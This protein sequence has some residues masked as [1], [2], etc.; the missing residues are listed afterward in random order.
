MPFPQGEVEMLEKVCFVSVSGGK[1][2]ALTLALAVERYGGSEIP[3]VGVFSDT[4]WEHPLTYG[5]LREL[6]E[7]FGIRI[8]RIS[9]FEGGLPALIRRKRIFPSARR[10]FCT[11]ILKTRALA[12]FYRWFYFQFPFKGAEVWSGIRREESKSRRN[13]SDFVLKKGDSFH[14]VSFPFDVHYVYPIKDLREKEVFSELQKRGVPVNP[15]YSLG[16][17]RVGC[18]PCFLSKREIVHLIKK[19]LDGDRFALSRLEELKELDSSCSSRIHINHSL[20]E[21]I[22]IA[23][24]ERKKE[25]LLLS[26]PFPDFQK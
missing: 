12:K 17:K 13:I 2:S 8:Q 9:G 26:L 25:S 6:E 16:Y 22:S 15:L 10:R 11:E 24:K 14:G 7:F 19:A 23:E 5:Y 18:F 3:V 4:G 1:D 21:L 20:S